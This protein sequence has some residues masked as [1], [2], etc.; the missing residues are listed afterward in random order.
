[1]MMKRWMLMIAAAL[2]VLP[3][4]VARRGM[5][6]PVFLEAPLDGPP[7]RARPRVRH[8]PSPS[9][10]RFGPEH[11]RLPKKP[12]WMNIQTPPEGGALKVAG[13]GFEPATFGL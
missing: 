9:L 12:E 6:T 8:R 2:L 13:A 3:G 10:L 5:R 7:F 4:R 1:M 11:R